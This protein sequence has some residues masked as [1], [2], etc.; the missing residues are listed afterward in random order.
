[1]MLKMAYIASRFHVLPQA[2]LFYL[3]LHLAIS[4]FISLGDY[5]AE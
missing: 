5:L 4:I 2:Y 3:R 1:M